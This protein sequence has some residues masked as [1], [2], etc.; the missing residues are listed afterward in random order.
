MA[1]IP[2]NAADC[3]SQSFAPAPL[4]R[5]HQF[6]VEIAVGAEHHEGLEGPAVGPSCAMGAGEWSAHCHGQPDAALTTGWSQRGRRVIDAIATEHPT[7]GAQP[8]VI[9]APSARRRECQV[10][11]IPRR[12]GELPQGCGNQP[13]IERR[14]VIGG[15]QRRDQSIIPLKWSQSDTESTSTPT[16]LQSTDSRRCDPIAGI[17]QAASTQTD[18]RR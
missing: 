15:G 16:R 7:V 8:N 17:D 18:L 14:R 9:A 3:H 6:P 2:Q 12:R 1:A 11:Q 13:A 5:Q 10:E 4:H